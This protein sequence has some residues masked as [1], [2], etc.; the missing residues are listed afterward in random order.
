LSLCA[1]ADDAMAQPIANAVQARKIFQRIAAPRA[2][3]RYNRDLTGP[4]EYCSRY[5]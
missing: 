4:G 5:M 1:A 2:C 3:G